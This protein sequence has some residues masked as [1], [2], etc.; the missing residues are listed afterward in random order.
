MPTGCKSEYLCDHQPGGADEDG[1]WYYLLVIS[2]VVPKIWAR[3]NSAIVAADPLL[4]LCEGQLMW[5]RRV[6]SWFQDQESISD[7]AGFS[8]GTIVWRG[9]AK[10][11]G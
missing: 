5:K 3:T 10:S 1:K 6:R 8:I 9:R 11:G 2:N 4:S 7:I